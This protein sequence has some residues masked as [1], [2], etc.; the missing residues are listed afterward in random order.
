[1]NG[2]DRVIPDPVAANR[3]QARLVREM[4]DAWGMEEVPLRVLA[5]FTSRTVTLESNHPEEVLNEKGLLD[6]LRHCVEGQKGNLDPDAVSKQ[7]SA[8]VERLKR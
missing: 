4:M 7:L 2:A 8:H 1:M 6:E 3:E 5:V